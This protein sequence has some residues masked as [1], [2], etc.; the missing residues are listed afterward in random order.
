MRTA[1]E[2]ITAQRILHAR[3]SA[4]APHLQAGR[5]GCVHDNGAGGLVP[6]AAE[7]LIHHHLGHHAVHLHSHA[8]LRHLFHF[9]PLHCILGTMNDIATVG[10]HPAAAEVL[11]QH[12]T[13]LYHAVHLRSN[14]NIAARGAHIRGSNTSYISFHAR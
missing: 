14:G 1:G 7:V 13:T 9:I 10:L 2:V 11:L 6:A 4:R 12:N 8:T 5:V 3:R